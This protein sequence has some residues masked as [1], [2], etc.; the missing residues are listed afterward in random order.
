MRYL[1]SAHM[2]A[3]DPPE[4]MQGAE[5]NS[6]LTRPNLP[7]PPVKYCII[8][9][10]R[11]EERFIA[12]AIDSV[13][14]QTIQPAEWIIVDDGSSDAT[15]GIVAERMQ[16]YSWI[17]FIQ[18]KN[19][20]YRSTGGGI[21][22]FLDAYPLLQTQDWEYLVNLDGDLTFA[23]DYFARCFEHFQE[24]PQLGIG[25]GTL[26]SRKEGGLEVERAPLFHVRGATKIYRREC[27]EK[28]GGLSRSLGWDTIDE[29][30]ANRLGWKTQSFE[31]LHLI[32]HRTS[33]T[34]WGEWRFAV[35]DGEADYLVGYHPAFFFFKCLR[36][37]FHPPYLLRGLAVAY[38]YLRCLAR[39]TPR[40]A[41]RELRNYLRRQQ[42]RCLLGMS[43][44]WR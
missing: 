14:G 15:A 6:K 8:T 2:R 44:I 27:W 35:L 37:L 33:G 16:G 42:L 25:G 9:A 24:M 34:A 41:D 36:H 19:R 39:R 17:Q 26:Y 23:P 30:K 5:S 11:D 21:E 10:V 29:I 7:V 18:R 1:L 40:I 28:L 13:V 12:G 31:D 20:G 43:S 4:P 3:D 38:G 22:A 32:H